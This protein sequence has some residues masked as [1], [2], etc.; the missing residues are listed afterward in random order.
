MAGRPHLSNASIKI[1]ETIR[2]QAEMSG[3]KV[4]ASIWFNYDNGWDD[5]SNKPIPPTEQQQAK[6]NSIHEQ[7]HEFCDG[8]SMELSLVLQDLNSNNQVLSRVKLFL[9]PLYN[10]ETQIQSE[11]TPASGFAALKGKI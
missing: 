11:D 8:K 6:I 4:K 5:G 9:N 10:Q 2:S 3:Q 1:N 7:M